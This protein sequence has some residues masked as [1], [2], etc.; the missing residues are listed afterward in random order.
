[1]STHPQSRRGFASKR[2]A[3]HKRGF[4]LVELL[5]VIAIIGVLVALL[6]PAVQQARESA[7]RTE[8]SNN[9][10]QWGLAVHNYHDTFHNLPIGITVPGQWTFRTALLP[11][12]EQQALFEQ[13][14]PDNYPHCFEASRDA[15]TR[16]ENPS[17][18]A[19]DAYFC[20]SDPRSGQLYQGYYGA[21]YMPTQYMGVLG[22][23]SDYPWVNNGVFY[24]NS[25]I[26]F[27]SIV[28][29][30]S[31]TLMI[32]ERSVP[33][34]LF[35]GWATCGATAYDVFVSFKYGYYKGDPKNTTGLTTFWSYHPGGA[36]FVSVDG[37]VHL[38]PYHTEQRVMEALATRDGGE[39]AI[40]N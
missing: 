25:K 22:S 19:V 35:W 12:L 17:D 8:C 21:D 6:L 37:S 7:R 27:Q 11:Y 4:T 34:N 3:S 18:D 15:H 29:G 20:P 30:T 28:D 40:A 32:G 13:I 23:D 31:N 24:I 2:G 39:V 26:G 38:Y 9:L 14:D 36:Q 33:D 16:G 5:V 10:K 1:M